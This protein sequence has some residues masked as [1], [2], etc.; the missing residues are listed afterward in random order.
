[1]EQT[2]IIQIP[3]ATISGKYEHGLQLAIFIALA[4]AFLVP[5]AAFYLTQ[6]LT[7]E[8]RARAALEKDLLNWLTRPGGR[9]ESSAGTSPRVTPS[10]SPARSSMA[11]ALHH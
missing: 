8:M 1:M 9:A 5:G 11:N 3:E 6:E 2:G 4:L 10:K 7:A